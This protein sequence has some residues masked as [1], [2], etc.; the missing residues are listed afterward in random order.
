M[1]A[2][3]DMNV[4]TLTIPDFGSNQTYTFQPAK[5]A[6]DKLADILAKGNLDELKKPDGSPLIPV[7]VGKDD[8]R[9]VVD[10]LTTR[11]CRYRY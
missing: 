2:A 3:N 6:T 1:I 11:C 7:T 9:K 5:N 8:M 10:L 4:P